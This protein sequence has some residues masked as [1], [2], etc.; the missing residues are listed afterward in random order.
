MSYC[1][2]FVFC[3]FTVQHEGDKQFCGFSAAIPR[4]PVYQTVSRSLFP[5]TALQKVY[6]TPYKELLDEVVFWERQTVE[7]RQT[8]MSALWI[9][10][11]LAT[12]VSVD[13]IRSFLPSSLQQLR[14]LIT[15]G[16]YWAHI[17]HSEISQD[18]RETCTLSEKK[19][20]CLQ[21]G[22]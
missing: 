17:Q 11:S 15:I 18:Q 3:C 7:E 10:I 13:E 4:L 16:K 20:I 14:G 1:L 12:A 6:L 2:G 8:E 22:I 19:D 21:T 5:L 9:L